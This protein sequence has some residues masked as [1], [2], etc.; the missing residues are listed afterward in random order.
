MALEHRKTVPLNAL[1]PLASVPDCE[2][3]SLQLGAAAAQAAS[4]PAGMIVHD[5]TAD[6]RDFADTA[7]LVD[8]LDL[9]ISVCTS[10]VHL[11]GAL[12]KPVWLLN[13]F[14]TDWRWFLDRGSV[15]LVSHHAD[16]PAAST[17]R[18][19]V[20]RAIRHRGPSRFH[21]RLTPPRAITRLF[22]SSFVHPL[23]WPAPQQMRD[24]IGQ[25]RPVQRIEVELIHTV[26]L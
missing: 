11:A 25:L 18:L 10:T 17:R 2:F 6:I 23:I 7:A 21:R 14:D 4:P 13:R 22:I 8:N 1:A 26:G 5:L 3:V 16:L 12:G 20:R 9:V 15:A 19:G 24:R